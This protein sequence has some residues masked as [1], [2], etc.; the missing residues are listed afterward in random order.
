MKAAVFGS[1]TYDRLFLDQANG[2]NQRTL[3]YFEP[4]LSA[5]TALLAIPFQVVCAFVHESLEEHMRKRTICFLRIC[6]TG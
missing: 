3:V 5:E 6:P 2:K 4:R 1:K